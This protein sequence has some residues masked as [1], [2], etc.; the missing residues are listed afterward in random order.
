MTRILVTERLFL[1][2]FNLTDTEFILQLLNTPG[3]LEFIGDRNVKTTE[4]AKSYLENGPIKS[5]EL[6]GFGLS[7]VGLKDNELPIGMCGLIKR[8]TL[9]NVD[10]GFAFLPEYSG[11]GYAVEIASAT[12]KYAKEKL[13][14]KEILA[15]TLPS[16][17]RSIN[18]LNKIGLYFEKNIHLPG[19]EQKLMLFK[20]K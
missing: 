20:S 17:V 9:E 11:E 2:E 12:M 7:L 19:D 5:Y 18:L 16:N 10:I 4:A 14:L 3:W 8:E 1:R 15:I 6:N 13:K